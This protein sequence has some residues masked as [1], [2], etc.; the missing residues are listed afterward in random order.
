MATILVC[1]S[2]RGLRTSPSYPMVWNR[3]PSPL[4]YLRPAVDRPERGKIGFLQ[5]ANYKQSVSKVNSV[6][7]YLFSYC[8]FG[9]IGPSRWS[10]HVFNVSLFSLLNNFYVI[11]NRFI[12]NIAVNR[13]GFDQRRL[14]FVVQRGSP[15]CGLGGTIETRRTCQGP[16]SSQSLSS[17]NHTGAI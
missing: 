2:L 5:C 14:P 1:L 10:L 16:N 6:N 13:F 17:R 11:V 7:K 3:R 12:L 4:L 8:T 9:S 15:G